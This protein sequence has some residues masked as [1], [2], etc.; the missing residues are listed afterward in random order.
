MQ[1]RGREREGGGGEGERERRRCRTVH[2]N[3]VNVVFLPE[4]KRMLLKNGRL[5]FL[6][7][8]EKKDLK[9]LKITHSQVDN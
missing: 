3:I 5:Q 7:F 9:K 1:G 8:H 2:K 4:S 6:L